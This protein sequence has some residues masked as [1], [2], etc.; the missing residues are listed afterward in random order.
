MSEAARKLKELLF[1]PQ[2]SIFILT[3]VLILLISGAIYV[4]LGKQASDS[5][6]EQMLHREQLSARA[7]AGSL[8]SFFILYGKAQSSFS[9]RR[10]IISPAENTN[11]SL[12]NFIARWEGTPVAGVIFVD[13][14][15][16]VKYNGNRQNAPDVGADVSDRSYFVWGKTAK[17]GEVLVSEPIISRLGASKGKY[18]VTVSTPVIAGDGSFEGL[19]A[20]AVI[21]G[22]LTDQYLDPLKISD[23]TRI[24]LVDNDGII[25]SSPVEKLIGVNYLDYIL[26]SG[27][28]GSQK[29][30]EIL[31]GSLESND[32]GKM[33][34]ALPDETKNGFLTRYL[35]ARAPVNV[36][37]EHWT[38]GV[39]TPASDALEYLAPF[40]FKNLGIAGLAFLAFLMI[41]IRVAKVVGYKEAVE[42]EHEAHGIKR[43]DN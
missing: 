40:Y 24:Y 39:A 30:Y 2:N 16:R 38:L 17:K 22:E 27:I 9:T 3:G 5:L 13:T 21:L 29:V 37:G 25:L 32:E 23:K 11:E 7:G 42:A 10:E 14:S 36:G 1:K 15:G 26:K 8:E 31:K 43:V 35:I 34:L 33:D 6:V 20:G 12:Y 4:L 28:P 19:L 41:A 18:V